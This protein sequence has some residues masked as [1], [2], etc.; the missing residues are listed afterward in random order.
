[1]S[2]IDKDRE[3]DLAS[4]RLAC[5]IGPLD[6][7][8]SYRKA[9]VKKNDHEAVAVVDDVLKLKRVNLNAQ[10]DDKLIKRMMRF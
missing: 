7:V 1:M 5:I 3:N 9:R 8:I 6:S 2:T 4:L 10:R